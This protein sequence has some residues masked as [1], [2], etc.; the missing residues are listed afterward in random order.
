MQVNLLDTKKKHIDQLRITKRKLV[1]FF[2]D[3]L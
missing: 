1:E 3:E 2:V